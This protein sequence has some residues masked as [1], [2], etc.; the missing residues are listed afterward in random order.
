MGRRRK[1][2]LT[3]VAATLVATACSSAPSGGGGRPLVV[4]TV[5]PITNIVQNVGGCAVRTVGIIPEGV[6]SHT[7]EPAPSDAALF[8]QA[9]VVFLNGLHLE[10][11]TR[12][13]AEANVRPGVPIVELGARTVAP[14]EYI[15]DFSFPREQGDPNPHLWTNPLYAGRYAE[16]VMRTLSDL[17]PDRADTFRRNY[18]AFA[19]RIRELDRLVREV[20][21]T[22]PPENRKLLTYHDS[23]PY[24]AREYGW[25]VIGAIQPSDFSDPTPQ[26]VA[27]LID[28]IRRTG[29]PAIFG[30]EVFPS[31][32]LEQIASETGARYIDDLRDDDLP[33][34]PGD[35]EHSYLGLM[36]FDFRTFMGALGGDA[37][38]LDG[39][40]TSNVAGEGCAEYRT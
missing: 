29:V 33:G 13:L 26:E 31:P 20:T 34:D 9:D 39:F 4:T 23:F 12:E 22:V 32:V 36:V 37:S 21:E 30:S 40:D 11:P 19:A 17:F 24:F 7:F 2:L 25:E 27:R 28:Q 38:A 16:I 8:E 35:P 1:S 15:F 3:L 6:D 5:S 14:D 10:E 18:E